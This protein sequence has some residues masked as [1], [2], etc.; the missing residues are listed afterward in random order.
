MR[1][2]PNKRFWWLIDQI[3]E[4]E[5][6]TGAEIGCANGSTTHRLLRACPEL[7]LFAVDKWEKIEGG[8]KAG[9]IGGGR[10][11][12]ENYIGCYNWDPVKGW[13]RF[14]RGCAPFRRRVKILRGDS[15]EM[16]DRVKDG[17][18]DFVFIDAD[19]RYAGVL[20][21]LKAWV[22]KLKTGGLLSGHDIHFPGVLHALKEKVP[23][24]HEAGV[25]NV[26]FA[27]KE[28]YVD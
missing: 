4:H 10:F 25:D 21:D 11:V 24:Y 5:F 28:D 26:W 20:R 12:D 13:A 17:S 2:K 16:A 8:P 18:L 19:H 27:K 6:K 22:P 9:D 15:V 7:F 23:G 14:T 1:N 3:H